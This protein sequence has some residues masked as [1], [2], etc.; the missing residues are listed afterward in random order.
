[1][2]IK[3]ALKKV[4]RMKYI[5]PSCGSFHQSCKKIVTNNYLENFFWKHLHSDDGTVLNKFVWYLS[6]IIITL[7]VGLTVF[8]L[9]LFTLRHAF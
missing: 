1:M 2:T 3:M 8:S 7:F 5:E 9:W 6:I 4:Y